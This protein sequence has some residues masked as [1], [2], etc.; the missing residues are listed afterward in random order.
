MIY[1]TCSEGSPISPAFETPE[2]LARWLTDNSFGSMTATYEQWLG[3]YEDEHV[4]I[5]S[6]WAWKRSNASGA[7]VARNDPGGG[8]V[9]RPWCVPGG[10]RGVVD[11]RVLNEIG[12]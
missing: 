12:Y 6:G 5:P 1:E 10:D 9:W 2:E 4:S 8:V 11:E 3:G 7:G